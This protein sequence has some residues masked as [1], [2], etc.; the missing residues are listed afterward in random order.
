MVTERSDKLWEQLRQSTEKYDYFITGLSAALTAFVTQG[1]PDARM[2]W[3]AES[4]EVAAAISLCIAVAAA[5]DRIRYLIAVTG[6]NYQHLVNLEGRGRLAS[7]LVKDGGAHLINESTG[8]MLSPADAH[9]EL[10]ERDLAIAKI[11][12]AL[13]RFQRRSEFAYKVRDFALVLGLALYVGARTW[14][15]Y[16]GQ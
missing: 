6:A 3:N 5:L 12:P 16:A 4:M 8:D 10:A 9:A 2:A 13:R 7:L 1:L 14:R 11:R 15:A